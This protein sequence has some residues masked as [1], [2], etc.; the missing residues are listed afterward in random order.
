MNIKWIRWI[1]VIA[2]ICA[3]VLSAG[4]RLTQVEPESVAAAP[5]V[6]V[7]KNVSL[8]MQAT[9]VEEVNDRGA[10]SL[11]QQPAALFVDNYFDYQINYPT[12]WEMNQLSANVVAFQATDGV[13]R[14]KVEAAGPMPADG[15]TPFVDRSLYNDVVLSRQVLT[16]HGHAAE[17]VVAFADS[18]GGQKTTFFIEAD[19]NAYVV[20]GVGQQNLIEQVARSFDAPQIL[21]LK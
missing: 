12:G 17:R 11:V 14:V 5:A 13:T 7:S 1:I 15:L 9:S 2:V 8:T 3:A 21:A 6:T 10:Q 20:T 18:P 4:Y 19:N 16:I